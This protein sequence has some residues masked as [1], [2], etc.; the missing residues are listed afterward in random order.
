[1]TLTNA[2]NISIKPDGMKPPVTL[3]NTLAKS[4]TKLKKVFA[5]VNVKAKLIMPAIII[6]ANDT[7]ANA[8]PNNA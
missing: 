7:N 6:I 4:S 5:N 2:T 8:S 3:S 1:M